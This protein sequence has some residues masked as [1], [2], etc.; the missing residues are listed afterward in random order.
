MSKLAQVNTTDMAAAIR[1]GCRT[2]QSMFNRDDHDIPFFNTWVRPDPVMKFSAA[3]SESHTPGRH[4]NALLSAEDA[5]GIKLDEIAVEK[6]RRAAFFSYGG[7]V[8]LPLNR[9]AIGGPLVNFCPHNIREGF[10]A[11]YALVNYRGDAQARD[12]A[13]RSIMAIFE[14]WTPAGGW[15]QA[16]LRELGLNYQECQGFIHGEARMLGPLVKYYHATGSA[17]ALELALL[18]KEKAI[19]E[20]F[21]PDGEYTEERFITR[22]AHSVTCVMS[23]LAQLADLLGDASL[24]ARVKAFYDRGLWQLRDAIGWSPELVGQRN[25]DHGEGNSTGDIVETALI[26]GRWGCPE[27]YQDAE[28]ILRCHLLPSQLRDVSFIHDPP[29]PKGEDG[30]RDV[31]DRH[32]GAFGFPAPYGH[33]SVGPGRG[34]AVSFNLDIVGG[35]VGSLCEAYREAAVSRPTSHWVNLLFD[36]ETDGLRVYSPYTHDALT[37]E[38]FK[39]A[40]LR[41]RLP[42]WAD[43]SRVT[44]E[45]TDELPRRINGYLFFAKPPVGSPIRI[46]FPLIEQQLTLAGAVH[47]QPIRVRLWGDTVVAMDNFDADLTFFDVYA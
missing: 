2:M 24:L 20:C 6:H 27:Y 17:R 19:T 44:V 40:P 47:I 42:F 1:L 33:E 28:R 31:A 46:R 43:F 7:P 13:E 11:L 37:I 35:V 10:H 26:L 18:L 22:H 38:V 3:H 29:N 5:A 32:S 39:A 45:G 8:P 9:Q 41:V 30:L 21:L 25:S 36:R 16:R 23:S 15:D 34:G 14:L 12:L 4:L